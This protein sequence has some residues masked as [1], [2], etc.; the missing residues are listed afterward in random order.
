MITFFAG[1][2][3]EDQDFFL[4]ISKERNIPVLFSY[5]DIEGDHT[6]PFRRDSWEMITNTLRRERDESRSGKAG[7]DFVEGKAGTGKKADR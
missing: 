5:Y 7:R 1:M 6:I 4:R 2:G 3:I